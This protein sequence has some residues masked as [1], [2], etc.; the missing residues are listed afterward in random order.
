M[1]NLETLIP[2]LRHTVEVTL[3]ETHLM[4][5]LSLIREFQREV[6]AAQATRNESDLIRSL[7]RF[8]RGINSYIAEQRRQNTDLKSKLLL[9]LS[10]VDVAV[11]QQIEENRAL[12]HSNHQY[13]SSF[14]EIGTRLDTVM[15]LYHQQ[16][17]QLQQQQE[18]MQALTKQVQIAEFYSRFGDYPGE[19]L[20]FLKRQSKLSNG[21]WYQLEDAIVRESDGYH[22]PDNERLHLSKQAISRVLSERGIT[23]AQF[24][25][26]VM[27]S[28]SRNERFHSGL[29][30]MSKR[31]KKRKIESNINEIELFPGTSPSCADAVKAFIRL[32]AQVH[33]MQLG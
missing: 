5:V 31:A 33:N 24:E 20:Q 30:K 12:R 16:Q 8:T 28:K 27:F 26:V 1:S 22:G 6:S 21:K 15:N 29:H 32:Y 3:Q 10:R 19:C 11:G 14:E 2:E 7:D 18:Q 17:S 9:I 13:Q 4:P 23:Y 25:I